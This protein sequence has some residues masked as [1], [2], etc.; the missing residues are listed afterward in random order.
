LPLP[1]SYPA[2]SRRVCD[3]VL[4]LRLAQDVGDYGDVVDEE[5]YRAR[6][7]VGV[8]EALPREPAVGQ[9]VFRARVE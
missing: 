1:L 9:T 6:V 4:E 3:A 7:F 2:G 8:P 5:E